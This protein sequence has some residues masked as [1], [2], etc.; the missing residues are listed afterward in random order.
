MRVTGRHKDWLKAWR[1]WPHWPFCIIRHSPTFRWNG[2]CWAEA[3][4]ESLL[5]NP[6]ALAVNPWV[7]TGFCRK[8]AE[9]RP[10][11]GGACFP[12]RLKTRHN[13]G[14]LGSSFRLASGAVIAKAISEAIWVAVDIGRVL[15]SA[16]I[17]V[18]NNF[19]PR[20][21][22]DRLRFLLFYQKTLKD[23]QCTVSVFGVVWLS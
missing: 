5:L 1:Q 9:R 17:I 10:G 8:R 23:W 14:I 21:S 22:E 7:W 12:A 16:E 3:T 2:L 18:L 19:K 15:K 11:R 4:E 6:E 13:K 20:Q